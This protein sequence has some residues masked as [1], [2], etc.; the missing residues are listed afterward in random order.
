MHHV[1]FFSAFT[2]NNIVSFLSLLEQYFLSCVFKVIFYSVS[3]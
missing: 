1:A 2:L 3:C